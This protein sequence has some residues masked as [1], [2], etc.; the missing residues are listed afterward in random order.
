[1]AEIESAARGLER[2][3]HTEGSTIKQAAKPAVWNTSRYKELW[4]LA[5]QA[6]N[7]QEQA[8]SQG[9]AD[10]PE[11]QADCA[12]GSSN[13]HESSD[14]SGNVVLR[15]DCVDAA[16]GGMGALD[17]RMD[18]E[19]PLGSGLSMLQSYPVAQGSSSDGSDIKIGAHYPSA[20]EQ[21]KPQEMT[22]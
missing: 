9:A 21:A 3:T 6:G 22:L 20:E 13:H 1:M 17:G 12:V 16:P 10:A 5:L 11:A 8:Q 2:S 4:N 14:M 15:A 7:E 18:I 19:F